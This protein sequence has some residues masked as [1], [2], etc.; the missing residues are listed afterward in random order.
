MQIQNVA[1][2]FG[3]LEV[4]R[5]VLGDFLKEQLGPET[6]G[7]LSV[8]QILLLVRLYK[9]GASSATTVKNHCNSGSNFPYN[10]QKLEKLGY[11]ENKTSNISRREVQ[12]ELTEKGKDLAQKTL[13]ILAYLNK[14]IGDCFTHEAFVKLVRLPQTVASTIP[15]PDITQTRETRPP[16]S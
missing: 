16:S 12:L 3:R 5:E 10:Y 14:E 1:D 13:P 2:L 4:A 6:C 15:R 9:V 8:T 11:L 7:D